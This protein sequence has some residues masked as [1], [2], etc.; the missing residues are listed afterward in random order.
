V[1]VQYVLKFID[2]GQN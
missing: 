1:K 2:H